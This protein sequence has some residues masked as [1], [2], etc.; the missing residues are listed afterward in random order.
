MQVRKANMLDSLD[1]AIESHIAAANDAHGHVSTGTAPCF[2]DLDY[3]AIQ[4]LVWLS[5]VHT[6][7][8]LVSLLLLTPT[9]ASRVLNERHLKP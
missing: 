1:L 9:V 2:C 8:L 3:V 6:E 5:R 7:C 4:G